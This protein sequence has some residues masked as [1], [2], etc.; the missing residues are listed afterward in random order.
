MRATRNRTPVVRN[1]VVY[2]SPVLREKAKPVTKVDDRIRCLAEDM[3]ETMRAR[4]GLGLAAEQIGETVAMCVIEIPP[5]A[6]EDQDGEPVAVPMPMVLINP[7]I[8]ETAGTVTLQEGCLSFPDIFVSVARALEVTAAFQDLDGEK[9]TVRARGL[10]ARAIQHELDHLA[11]VLLVDRMS[12]IKK[13][14]L[15]GKLKKLKKQGSAGP[16]GS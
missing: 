10:L 5:H 16:V 9:R 1:V 15:S 6:L 2:G 13:I 14:S 8:V 11:G 12:V 3:I 4:N 7:K